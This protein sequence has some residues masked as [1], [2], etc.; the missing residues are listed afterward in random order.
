MNITF[1]H[2]GRENLG[3]EYLSAAAKQAG[4]R[5]SL[6]MDPGLFGINDNVFYAP[7]LEKIFNQKSIV[8]RKIEKSNPD[9]VAFSV[10]TGTFKWAVDIA[11]EIKRKL[12]VKTV[13]GG[14]HVTLVPEIVIREKSIDFLIV[15]EGEEAFVEL[16]EA[17]E[18]HKQPQAIKNLWRRMDGE[19]IKNTLR[20]PVKDLDALPLPDKE[21]F[22]KD[23]NYGDDYLIMTSRGCPYNCSYCCES[24]YNALYDRK[25]FRRRSV[26]SVLHELTTM[27]KR[28]NFKEV[29]FNDSIFF[30]NLPWLKTLLE[31]YRTR[32][33]VPFRCFGRVNAFSEEV[34]ELLKSAGCYAIE[35]GIQTLNE[36]LRKNI[37]NRPENNQDSRNAFALCDTY[38]ISYDIDHMFGLPEEKEEDHAY[39]ARVYGNLKH[40]NRVK[41]HN[42]MYFP[43][44][45]ITSLAEKK[46]ILS[47]SDVQLIGAGEE[48]VDFF[49]VD[50]VKEAEWQRINR[51]YKTLYKMLPL[52]PPRLL[53]FF[54]AHNMQRKLH[55]V[56]H[57]VVVLLQVLVAIRGKDYRFILYIRY[58]GRRIK[59]W[60]KLR[61][62]PGT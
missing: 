43:K 8:L 61:W 5:V 54:L 1:V 14:V 56:P 23:I 31:K 10:Y 25:F 59:R 47:S 60:L 16:L 52:L 28:Y 9:L 62:K 53:K 37:L 58:Y 48:G 38:G 36:P 46:G 39:A 49:H 13:F 17:L 12:D 27:K 24:Y 30:T 41:C 45:A 50:S 20:P 11:R 6:A 3:I 29:M 2:L 18:T 57:P 4:H 21:L 26:D 42:L 15:G 32:I 51:S 33:G 35:F 34:A 55:R 44:L 40:L 22:E 19:V 7:F